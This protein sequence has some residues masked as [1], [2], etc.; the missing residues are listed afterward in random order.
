MSGIVMRATG[1]ARI[2]GAD[3]LATATRTATARAAIAATVPGRAARTGIAITVMVETAPPV[4]APTST[5]STRPAGA[6]TAIALITQ[7][8]VVESQDT[9]HKRRSNDS[10][11]FLR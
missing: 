9:T 7:T 11:F 2:A 5:F 10:A 4:T 6:P 1:T 8:V 3:T